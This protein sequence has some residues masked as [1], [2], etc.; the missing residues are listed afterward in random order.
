MEVLKTAFKWGTYAGLIAGGYSILLIL[1]GIDP[2]GYAKMAGLWIPGVF[3]FKAM[4][5]VK[6][7]YPEMPIKYGPMFRM[8]VHVSMV[9]GAMAAILLY[10][11]CALFQL[12]LIALVIQT[13]EFAVTQIKTAAPEMA[14]TYEKAM[15]EAQYTLSS[16]AWSDFMSK[17]WGGL[18]VASIV[19][20]FQ[21]RKA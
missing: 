15:E 5:E 16:L 17:F 10:I 7:S 11:A 2:L 20:I 8:G 1:L 13:Q 19:A 6:D 14:E 12:D 4:K 21:R 18:V 3:A 9:Y